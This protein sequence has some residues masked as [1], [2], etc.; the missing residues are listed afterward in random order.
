[1]FRGT[2]WPLKAQL[3][4]EIVAK[5][6]KYLDLRVEKFLTWDLE[7]ETVCMAKKLEKTVLLV[8]QV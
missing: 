8:T 4:V 3:E 1:M 5:Q 7:N 6:L 2:I